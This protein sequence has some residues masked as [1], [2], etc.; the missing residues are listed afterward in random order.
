MRIVHTSDWHAGRRWHRLDRSDELAA[1]LDHLC[2]YVAQGETDLVLV[3]GDLFD[4]G[5]PSAEAFDLVLRVL[6]RLGACCPVVAIAGNHDSPRRLDALAPLLRLANV[7]VVGTPRPVAK[8]GAIELLTRNGKAIVAALPF[9]PTKMLVSALERQQDDTTAYQRYADG[10]RALVKH[11]CSAFADDAVN[12]LVAHT[13]LEG[14]E[15]SN[16]ERAVHI[17]DQWA[18]P[19]QVLPADAHYVALGHIHRPQEVVGTGCPAVYAGS[20]LQLD[21]GEE[22]ETKSFVVIEAEPG[23]PARKSPIPYEGGRRL[24]TWEG[25]LDELSHS[26]DELRASGDH[27]RIQLRLDAPQPDIA[28]HVRERVPNAVVIRVLLP[29]PAEAQAQERPEAPRPLFEAYYQE[30][31]GRPPDEAV[32]RVFEDVYERASEEAS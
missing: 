25:S 5:A 30:R 24:R 9:A 3:S 13:H 23:K 6:V 20:P 15:I 11:L 10:V 19:A 16:S 32:T 18:A 26:A 2:R 27:V 1:V 29:E 31:Y 21:F 17:G 12:L 22:G 8:G 7:H 4:N 28:N 14:A